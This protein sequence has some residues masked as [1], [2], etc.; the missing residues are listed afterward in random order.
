[1]TQTTPGTDASA[2]AQT[3]TLL[4][5]LLAFLYLGFLSFVP[6]FSAQAL[7]IA[8]L[9]VSALLAAP[10]LLTAPLAT[11]TA[12]HARRLERVYVLAV[13]GAATV[14]IALLGGALLTVPGLGRPLI[15]S[16]GAAVTGVGILIWV[17]T[18]I[19]MV[20]VIDAGWRSM[21]DDW[22]DKVAE[23]FFASAGVWLVATTLFAAGTA[24][25]FVTARAG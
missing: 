13:A 21:R 20:R 15:K 17:L 19:V 8:F 23:R 16:V 7:S 3:A 18:A 9:S 22:L 4:A 10:A 5:A 25:Q 11:L 1:V 14:G 24:I 2:A 12:E 6:H